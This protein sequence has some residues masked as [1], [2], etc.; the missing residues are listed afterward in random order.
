VVRLRRD[1]IELAKASQGLGSAAA[2]PSAVCG[3]VQAIG[4]QGSY[5]KVTIHRAGHEDLI[6]HLPDHAFFLMRMQRGDRV[7]ARWAVEDVHLLRA[8]G[9]RPYDQALTASGSCT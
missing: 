4:Y 9:G 7:M 5:V 8:V 6:A 2:G 1:R 3:T